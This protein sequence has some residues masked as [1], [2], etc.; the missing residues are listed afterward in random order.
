MSADGMDESAVAYQAVEEERVVEGVAGVFEH[1]GSVLG[2]R[3]VE[4]E[5]GDRLAFILDV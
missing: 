1:D 3:G 2:A 5:L 4:H